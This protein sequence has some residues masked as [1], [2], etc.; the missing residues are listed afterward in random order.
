MIKRISISTEGHIECKSNFYTC[1]DV[2]QSYM[3]FEFV[4]GVNRIVGEIDS[5]GFGI[6]Y[7]LS[8]YN[9]DIKGT[10]F[11]ASPMITVDGNCIKL[12]DFAP[13]CCYLDRKY[14]LFSSEKTVRKLVEKG[15]KKSKIG[16][17]A[18]EICELFHMEDFRFDKPISSTGNERYKAMSAIGYAYGK[19]VF[20]FPWLSRLRFEAFHNHM[21]QLLNTLSEL[22]KIVILP[23]G[24]DCLG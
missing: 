23:L 6:S 21:P 10:D 17:T 11:L 5:G 20:C 4:P 24:E 12:S 19:E 7:L 8:M 9:I 14:P 2:L 3:K 1:V 18:D 22:N 13:A 16:K 15:L